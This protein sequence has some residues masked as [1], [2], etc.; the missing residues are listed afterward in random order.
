[1]SG[2]DRLYRLVVHFAPGEDGRLIPLGP[3]LERVRAVGEGL[4]YRQ[5][6]KL[7]DADPTSLAQAASRYGPLGPTHEVATIA[8]ERRFGWE[9][10]ESL[11]F[12]VGEIDELLRWIAAGGGIAVAIPGRLSR[13]AHLLSA[14][15]QMEPAL[16]EPLLA[17]AEVDRSFTTAERAHLGELLW[18]ES[19]S[20]SARYDA[21]GAQILEDSA[22]GEEPV[23]VRLPP[24]LAPERLRLAAKFLQS[25]FAAMGRD[26]G[27]GAVLEP[28]SLGRTATLLSSYRAAEGEPLQVLEMVEAWQI[29][30][31]ELAAWT[32]V[33]RLLR[34]AAL[35]RSVTTQLQS[36][37]TNI[38]TGAVVSFADPAAFASLRAAENAALQGRAASLLTL[39]L[40]QVGAW[41]FPESEV[42]GAFG[43][44]LWS[45][46]RPVNGK[47]PPRR[48]QWR[49]GCSRWLPDGAHG[50]RRYCELHE[51]EAPAERA[52]RS[53][54][55][56]GDG[57]DPA[58]E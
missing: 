21:M 18:S 6:A 33:V 26:G 7:V 12:V 44:A 20:A 37:L 46:W 23:Y 41:P 11:G 17:A 39:R 55:R 4:L 8:D 2:T 49:G 52:R 28:G 32:S 16:V 56:M 35:G 1:M 15:A 48:C 22:R 40:Q 34:A 29:A 13:T 38:G 58:L 10:A 31:R 45:L 27:A 3:P 47:Q 43:R 36:A 57:A 19:L 5:L 42:V 24:G 50:N 53:R 9:M 51:R 14:F 30:A 54:R 25:T